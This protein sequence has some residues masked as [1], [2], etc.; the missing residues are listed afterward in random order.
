[1]RSLPTAAAL[2]LAAALAGCYPWGFNRAV[3]LP[4][5]GE[6]VT[7]TGVKVEEIVRG[8]GAA[9]EPG[10]RAKLHYVV[11]LA[12]GRQVDS[13]YDRAAPFEVDVGAGHVIAGWE[14]GL[15]GMREGGRRRLTIPPERAY[16]ERGVSG[17]IPPGA[18][19]VVECELL[20]VEPPRS[21]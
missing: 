6:S 17:V 18:I 8:T 9:I 12:D 11:R 20:A 3:D 1:M 14:D 13:S 19:I 5:P 16:G 4:P 21:N 2:A 15:I 10:S 7:A